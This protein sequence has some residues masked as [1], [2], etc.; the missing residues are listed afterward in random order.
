MKIIDED[1]PH[2]NLCHKVLSVCDWI[3]KQ[4]EHWVGTISV[5]KFIC[6]Y[7]EFVY[8]SIFKNII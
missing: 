5:F 6:V 4:C 8:I 7:K 3:L 2:S 1:L